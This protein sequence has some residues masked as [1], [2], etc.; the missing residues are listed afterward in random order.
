MTTELT[1]QN[2][3]QA[4]GPPQDDFLAFLQAS[5]KLRLEV[6]REEWH[7]DGNVECAG[8]YLLSPKL[9]V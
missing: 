8:K 2:F 3:L 6:G 9:T 5:P 7:T 1:F 4:T